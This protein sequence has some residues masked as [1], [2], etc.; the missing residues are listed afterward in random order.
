MNS[1]LQKKLSKILLVSFLFQVFVGYSVPQSFAGGGTNNLDMSLSASVVEESIVWNSFSLSV[2]L[3]NEDTSDGDAFNPGFVLEIPSGIS[4]VS[5][6]MGD[7]TSSINHTNGNTLLFFKTDDFLPKWVGKSYQIN[8]QSET[9]VDLFTSKEINVLAY[10]EDNIYGRWAAPEWSPPGTLAWWVDI[11]WESVDPINSFPNNID[12]NTDLSLLPFTTVNTKFIPYSLTKTWEWDFL[13]GKIN[14]TNITLKWNDL[15]SLNDFRL[16]D[17]I[18]NTRKFEWFIDT[19]AADNVVVNYDSPAPWQV[20]LDFSGVQVATGSQ[21]ILSYNTLWLA[22]EAASYSGT[23]VL[24]N[25]GALVTN[26]SMSTNIVSMSSTWSWFDGTNRVDVTPASTLSPASFSSNL[27]YAKISKSVNKANPVIGDIIQYTV[28]LDVAENVD[29]DTAWSGTYIRDILP[30]GLSFTWTYTSNVSWSSTALEMTSSGT[31]TDGETNL[32]WTLLSGK[33]YNWDQVSITYDVLVDGQYEWIGDQHYENTET[34]T[35]TATFYGNVSDTWRNEEWGNT[36][37]NIINTQVTDSASAEITAP[38]PRWNKQLVEIEF[39]DGSIYNAWN[40]IWSGASIPVGSRLDFVLSMYFPNVISTGAVLVDA[41]PLIAGPNTSAYN[42][43]FQTNTGLLDLDGNSVPINDDDYDGNPD[44]TINGKTLGGTWPSDTS[45]IATTPANNIEFDIGGGVEEKEFSIR[46]SV[47]ILP[48]SPSWDGEKSLD[49]KNVLVASFWDFEGGFNVLSTVKKSFDIGFPVIEVEKQVTSGQTDISYGDTVSY[50][51][52]AKNTWVAAGYLEEIRDTFPENMTLSGYTITYSGGTTVP[53]SLI[54]QSGSELIIEFNTWGTLWRSEIQVDQIATPWIDES[55]ILIEYNLSPTQDFVI[56]QW[57]LRENTLSLDYFSTSSA[58]SNE[59]NRLWTASG[60]AIFSVWWPTISRTIISS[61]ESDSSPN[62]LLYLGEEVEFQTVLTL[63]GG[64]YSSSSFSEQLHS[65]LEFLSG[66]VISVWTGVTISSGTGFTGQSVNFWTI[67][68]TSTEDKQIIIRATARVKNTAVHA[69]NLTAVWRFY[70]SWTNVWANRPIDVRVP[71]LIVTKTASPTSWDASDDFLYTITLQHSP[72]SSAPAYD[73]NVTD[74]LP[75]S[76]SYVPSSLTWTVAFSG[77]DLDLFWSGITLEK[78]DLWS[79]AIFSFSWT[80]WTWAIASD[81]RTNT[82]IINYSS[83]DDDVSLYEKNFSASWTADI[84]VGDISLSH[85]IISTSHSGTSNVRF[86]NSYP[87][88]TIGEELVFEIPVSIP[89]LTFTGVTLSQTLPEWME[90]LTWSL[91]ADNVVSHDAI[92]TSF[93]GA[94]NRQIIFN[95]WS[96]DNLWVTSGSWFV[97]RTEARLNDTVNNTAWGVKNSRVDISY[98]GGNSK[99][100]DSQNIDVVEPN[101]SIGKVFSPTQWDGGDIISTSITIQNTGT[102]PAY[103]I[104]WNDTLAPKTTASG[105]Y[106]ASGSTGVLLPG[107][108]FTYSYDSILNSSVNYGE[109]LTWTSSIVGHSLFLGTTEAR[110]YTDSDTASI[111][112]TWVSWISKTHTTNQRST[113]ADTNHFVV[114]IPVAEGNTSSLEV[115]DLIP[116]W[117]MYA[118]GSF[119]WSADAAITFSWTLSENP[120][121]SS[122]SL[123]VGQQQ[124]LVLDFTNI[125]NT[126]TD[127]SETEFIIFEYD[128]IVLNSSDNNSGDTKSASVTA[129]YGSGISIENANFTP[130]EIIEPE[131]SLEL[132]HT[133][134][135][136]NTVEYIYTLTNSWSSPAYDVN[137]FSTLDSWVSFSWS[138]NLT[139]SGGVVWLS[140]SWSN[141]TIDSLPI[142]TGNPLQFSLEAII[143]NT[144]S[145]LDMLTATASLNYT[146]QNSNYTSETS[147]SLETERNGDG[148]VNDY[149]DND[150]ETF[151][152]HLPLLDESITVTDITVGVPTIIGDTLEYNIALTNTWS[153]AL[154]N[155]SVN[156]DVPAA[157]TWFVIISTPTW[158]TDNSSASGW[159]NGNGQINVSWIDIP[160]WNTVN[161][162]YRVMARNDVMSGTNVSTQTTVSNSQEWA[163]WWTPSV[164]VTILAPDMRLTKTIESTNFSSPTSSGDTLEYAFSIENIWDVI[165]SNIVL[166]DPLLGG[167]I[168]SS[169]TFPGS[170][171]LLWTWQTATCNHSYALIQDDVNRWYI[172]NSASLSALDPSGNTLQDISDAGD[173]STETQSAT[174]ATDGDP[175]N[176][177]TVQTINQNTGIELTKAL[178]WS[179]IQ[180]PTQVGDTLSYVMTIRNTWN[181]P[182]TSISLTDAKL[183]WNIT[184]SCAFSGSIAPGTSIQCNPSSYSVTQNDINAWQVQNVASLETTRITGSTWST[185]SNTVTQNLFQRPEASLSV[186]SSWS[187]ENPWDTV[188][189]IFSVE[190]TGNTPLDNITL[191]DEKCSA[192]PVFQGTDLWNDNIFSPGE[193]WNYTCVSTPATQADINT[194]ILTNTGQVLGDFQ[195]TA[196]TGSTIDADTVSIIANPSWTFTKST[197]STPEY[198]GDTLVYDFSVENTWNVSIS[199]ISI[200]DPKCSSTPTYLSWSDIWIIGLLDRGETWDY[201]CTSIPVTQAEVD[202]ST[203]LNTATVSWTAQRWTLNSQSGSTSTFIGPIYRMELSK[204]WSHIDSNNNS[205]WEI[206]ESIQFNFELRNTGNRDLVNIVLEDPLLAYTWTISELRVWEVYRWFSWSYDLE[207]SDLTRWYVENS[208]TVI[209]RNNSW[210]ILAQDVSDAWDETVETTTGTGWV[211]GD[212]TN[213]PTVVKFKPLL[214]SSWSFSSRDKCPNGDLSWSYYDKKCD[215]KVKEIDNTKE[216]EKLKEFSEELNTKD[217]TIVDTIQDF[218]SDNKVLNNSQYTQEFIPRTYDYLGKNPRCWISVVDFSDISNHTFESYIQDLEKKSWLNWNGA[219]NYF[220]MYLA[221]SRKFEPNRPTTRSEYIK[222]IMRALCIDYSQENI[223]LNN[224]SDVDVDPW[225]AK[226]VNLAVELGWIDRK[227][228]YFRVNDPI[229]RIEALKIIMLAGIASEFPIY[230]KSS[231]TDVKTDE[232][233]FY[234]TESAYHYG[235][236]NG[237]RILWKLKYRPNDS[238]LRWE[239]SK[240]IMNT[241]FS[242]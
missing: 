182:I 148:W 35:N 103:S 22:Y 86:N 129:N 110:E 66:S 9:D 19:S 117:L 143:D 72:S 42:I 104:T 51:V 27:R 242:K 78:L 211:D 234:Y 186:S 18:P 113:I 241:L 160:V 67:T 187:L 26:E 161:I 121:P 130:I 175:T 38:S 140:Q 132:S 174:W 149:S 17:V 34:I 223:T 49:I 53:N 20:T 101:I 192:T 69:D 41:L 37:P 80:L 135:Y 144:V 153:V 172:E 164:D 6:E 152:V 58:P 227:N 59:L 2:S 71:D 168:T 4:F 107:Q 124:K 36:N 98:N 236:T 48:V 156:H 62:D 208:A 183:W 127:N 25:T 88:L 96:I 46:F 197:N 141:F 47:D 77:S 204:T 218:F 92:S 225:Q 162:I 224:F 40:P 188:E 94:T 198:A 150:T 134:S 185:L 81:T 50:L 202:L 109:N 13:I 194:G 142:N 33:L 133:Y 178:S 209:S 100:D 64:T 12:E 226:V 24:L 23:S 29:F 169:C 84:Y 173:E 116:E 238:I 93:S 95:I 44:T 52:E 125:T 89:E 158:S 61:S 128:T 235:I 147:N 212:T 57:S 75:T 137:I 102:A 193:I 190:N 106:T 176:D 21:V 16:I 79:N 145:D 201:Q 76:I 219:G 39:P 233:L 45:W 184:S 214:G 3:S 215:A 199:N 189:Y 68:N 181:L 213:D 205:Y 55:T 114:K 167:D 90:F 111:T 97:F 166:D 139:N 196:L 138:Y 177:P 237:Q 60:S 163:E 120:S 1:K 206:G 32:I 203:T 91:I 231:F 123:W 73:V 180:N 221:K 179:T 65:S 240:F 228:E 154:T 171:A 195:W 15:G 10:A 54:T 28:T 165:L 115:E 43:S 159:I 136:G 216:E 200:N 230:S 222:M 239:T 191:T 31:L 131:L 82:A 207:R 119:S 118:P 74:V 87:D 146:S 126:D 112:I 63:P 220:N 155:I 232:W 14:T 11:A 229:S 30:D 122:N 151:Q 157:F 85:N 170:W 217:D 5:S 8:L 70:Y 7:Y 99:F 56:S 210:S 105:S 83:L 108:S